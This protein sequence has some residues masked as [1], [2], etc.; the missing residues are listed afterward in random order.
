MRHAS[1]QEDSY[2]NST[3]ILFDTVMRSMSLLGG[4]GACPSPPPQ[5]IF[6][7]RYYEIES[8]DTSDTKYII[9]TQKAFS[10]IYIIT[11]LLSVI[12]HNNNNGV[13]S[14]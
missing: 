2:L 7:K 12:V 4:L 14:L 5:E 13:Y 11:I 10:Q 3:T 6:E 1:F 8:G 9:A